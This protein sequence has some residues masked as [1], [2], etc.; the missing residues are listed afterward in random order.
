MRVTFGDQRANAKLSHQAHQPG[1]DSCVGEAAKHASTDVREIMRK[2]PLAITRRGFVSSG[3]ALATTLQIQHAARAL[4]LAAEGGVC[5]L[6]AEQEVGPYYV[7]DEL[8]RS[9]IVEGKPG[10][11]LSL[12]IMVLDAS[13]CKP[14]AN[15]AVDLWHCD[16]A[17]LY[18]GFTAQ[19][20][21]GPGGPG[22][23]PPGGPPPGFD[24]EHPDNRPGP[25][26]SMGPAPLSQP[27]DKLTFLRGIQ[28]TDA[29][30]AVRFRTVFPGFY[31]GRT[32]HI[33]FKV[34]VGGHASKRSYAAGHTSHV[35]QVFFPEEVATALMR[36]E[37]YSLHKIHRTTQAEDQ[38]FNDQHGELC[39]ARIQ[40][41][42]G[43]QF[44]AGMH[45]EMIASVDPMAT[46]AAAGRMGGPGG[47]HP[48][49]R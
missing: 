14:L 26:E 8:L 47:M 29:D 6:M 33:H 32:N 28:L 13:S 3:L 22:G 36:H 7:A 43:G 42:R 48:P 11:P 44:S 35:G 31:M 40:P 25:P 38:V 27:T 15:A 20:P 37:P 46:P 4:G 24:P 30:G 34:R 39:I 41:L 2:Q 18:S 17:G 5:N 23:G 49:G 16:A 21:T 45:A 10:V 9:D 19:N 12:R 1:F